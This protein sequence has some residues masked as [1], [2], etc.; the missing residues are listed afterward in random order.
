MADDQPS[1]P[2]R[3]PKPPS[4]PKQAGF[5]ATGP[6]PG[7]KKRAQT[8]EDDAEH[9]VDGIAD[10]YSLEGSGK[11]AEPLLFKAF[12]ET[13]ALRIF[14]PSTSLGILKGFSN[15]DV[16]AEKVA[17]VLGENPYYEDQFLRWVD[18]LAPRKE[19][20]SLESAIVLVGMQNARDFVLALQ[21]QR[22]ILRVHLEWAE[23][24]KLNLKPKEFIKYAIKTE[25]ILQERK[26]EYS[27]M[28][29]AAG[30]LFDVLSQAAAKMSPDSKEIQDFIGKTYEHGVK[31]AKIAAEICPIFPQF[32]FKKYAFTAAL[33]HD[34]GK[35]AMAI[36][37]PGYLKFQ[38]ECAEKKW[39]RAVRQFVEKKRFGV[40]HP[41]FSY[42][43]CNLFGLFKPIERA[44][45]C[46]HEPYL[47]QSSKKS[48][49]W[50][51]CAVS[52]SSNIANQFKKLDKAD[53]PIIA[54]W[55]GWDLKDL[56][57]DPKALIKA[58]G[59]VDGK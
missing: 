51:A 21:I 8:P 55:K 15:I 40:E 25:E 37:D 35:I 46:H 52:L 49:Y 9:G 33:V 5:A 4:V 13:L 18:S 2:P 14:L 36:L 54:T 42:L 58:L 20:I 27:D 50:L 30:F 41:V 11:R 28:A 6:L 53:D 45:L 10:W 26:N 47:L 7:K 39:P 31:S 57:I 12:F 32:S 38:A 43:L 44:V 3:T 16:T 17:N 1:S 23:G 48:H 34:V 59:R 29:Y 24:G 22:W 56:P 19:P